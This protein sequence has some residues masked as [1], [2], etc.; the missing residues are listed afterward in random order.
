MIDGISVEI[1]TVQRFWRPAFKK[2]AIE[3]FVQRLIVDLSAARKRSIFVDRF[4]RMLI[5]PIVDRRIPGAGVEC[6]NCV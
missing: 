5:R 2:S 3:H 4:A 1:H 6:Q